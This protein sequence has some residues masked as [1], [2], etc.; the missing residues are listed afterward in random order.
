MDEVAVRLKITTTALQDA[1]HRGLDEAD[2]AALGAQLVRDPTCGRFSRNQTYR[3][4]WRD[5]TAKYAV[6]FRED[7]EI[8]VYL[9]R[10]TERRKRPKDL[11]QVKSFARDLSLA[12]I[13]KKL[14]ELLDG[15]G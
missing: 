2:M 12:V 1:A 7:D 13:R 8:V 11:K 9:L 4:D 3:Y 14:E 15:E 6:R 5:V 10:L